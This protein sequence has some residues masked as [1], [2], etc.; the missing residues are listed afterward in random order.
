M[1][2]I[3]SEKRF[4]KISTSEIH[5][6]KNAIQNQF[7]FLFSGN[8]QIL[9]NHLRFTE[10]FMPANYLNDYRKEIGKVSLEDLKR[11]GKKYF[12]YSNL[13]TFIVGPKESYHFLE[14]GKSKILPMESDF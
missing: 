5:S 12:V 14:S 2:E 13:K 1:R 4:E 11:V 8:P 7:V 10:D 9:S 6:A 3:L